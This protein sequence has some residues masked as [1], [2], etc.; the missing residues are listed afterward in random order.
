MTKIVTCSVSNPV[1]PKFTC[2][3]DPEH[4]GRHQDEDGVY[5]WLVSE[6]ALSDS[7]AL[8]GSAGIAD[9]ESLRQRLSDA[10][11]ALNGQLRE[12]ESWLCS[13]HFGVEVGVGLPDDLRLVF[14]NVGKTWGLSVFDSSDARRPLL[15]CRRAIRVAALRAMPQLIDG[16]VTAAATQLSDVEAAIA[17]GSDLLSVLRSGG[18]LALRPA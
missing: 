12:V 17:G 9:A 13:L 7:S 1:F 6:P 4:S 5:S 3:L 16:L 11:E 18:A 10:S 14:S 8:I 15:E 2:A